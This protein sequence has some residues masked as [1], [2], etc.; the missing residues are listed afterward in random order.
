LKDIR[1]FALVLVLVVGLTI[2]VVEFLFPR[3]NIPNVSA[4]ITTQD[5]GTYW[6]KNCSLR[7]YSIDWGSL[8]PGEV[9]EVG[10]YVRNEGT[11]PFF[12]VLGP[13]NLNPENAFDYLKFSWSSEARPLNI[14]RASNLIGV[15]EVAKVTQSL[16]VHPYIKGISSFSFDLLFE[17]KIYAPMNLQGDFDEDGDIDS[18]DRIYMAK[19]YRTYLP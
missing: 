6:D 15:G 18:V 7:V 16:F 2:F 13:I 4:V 3:T 19:A 10:I 11:G 1:A 17:A 9:K 8:S 14:S 5:I 12:L